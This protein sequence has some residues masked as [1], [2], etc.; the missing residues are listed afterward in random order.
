MHLNLIVDLVFIQILIIFI[1]NVITLMIIYLHSIIL[2]LFYY[3]Y[4]RWIDF[5][6]F[7]SYLSCSDN[8]VEICY[9]F[10]CYIPYFCI[11][12][13]FFIYFYLLAALYFYKIMSISRS[14]IFDFKV[15]IYCYLFYIVSYRS[16]FTFL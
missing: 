13:S 4:L 5:S 3:I 1:N 9:L 8:I 10:S 11:Y 6:Y 15:L 12:I 14:C 7:F 2:F 16:F